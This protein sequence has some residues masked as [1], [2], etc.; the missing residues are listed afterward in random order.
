MKHC[1]H[2]WRPIDAPWYR[3]ERC[4]MIGRRRLIG[5]GTE[6]RLSAEPEPVKSWAI[7]EDEMRHDARRRPALAEI[8]NPALMK[9]WKETFE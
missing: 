2:D 6:R 5:R 7:D 9:E 3:C 8:E 4:G 1:D